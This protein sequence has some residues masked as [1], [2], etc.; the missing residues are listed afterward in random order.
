MWNVNF[1]RC[2]NQKVTRLFLIMWALNGDNKNR[3]LRTNSFTTHY[4]AAN[5]LNKFKSWL[6][7][8]ASFELQIHRSNKIDF[9]ICN[10][11]YFFLDLNWLFLNK[12]FSRTN[13][14]DLHF[15]CLIKF[16][17]ISRALILWA[18]I[19]NIFDWVILFHI[20]I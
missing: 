2:L 14:F 13:A 19:C 5:R 1:M 7:R 16:Q 8:I 3:L 4:K 9:Y 15:M 11:F 17:M 6:F 18:W 20:I 12:Q 10:S